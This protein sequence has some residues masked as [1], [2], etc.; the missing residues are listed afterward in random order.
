MKNYMICVKNLRNM[1]IKWHLSQERRPL[2]LGEGAE[3][4][5]EGESEVKTSDRSNGSDGLSEEG[6]L[7]GRSILGEGNERSSTKFGPWMV[8]QRN[9]QRPTRG[10]KG[11][12][13]INFDR[14]EA[15]ISGDSHSR[16]TNHPIRSSKGNSNVSILGEKLGG[17][18]FAVHNDNDN[19]ETVVGGLKAS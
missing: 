17:S 11:N 12:S 19:L 8:A 14:A 3:Q 2:E 13:G 1:V 9:R 16:Q 10:T 7:R 18:R 15:N 6:E 4:S 5:M